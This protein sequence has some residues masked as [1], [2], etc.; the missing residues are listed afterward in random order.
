M[1]PGYAERVVVTARRRTRVVI[2]RLNDEG[3]EGLSVRRT[4]VLQE[5]HGRREAT[6]RV[7]AASS[8][9]NAQR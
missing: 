8:T 1:R 9:G 6:I 3:A 4:R 7:A 2:V 5:F